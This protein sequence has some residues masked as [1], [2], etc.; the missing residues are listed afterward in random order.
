MNGTESQR[1]PFSKLLARAI[2][3]PGL[4]V[5]GPWGRNLEISWKTPN[6]QEVSSRMFVTSQQHPHPYHPWNCYIYLH[7]NHKRST[8]HVG[9][10]IPG[11][12]GSLWVTQRLPKLL[13]NNDSRP[14]ASRLVSRWKEVW[15]F[16][17]PPT[18]SFMVVIT[19][20]A[21]EVAPGMLFLFEKDGLN[22]GG[23]MKMV[24]KKTEGGKVRNFKK[25]VIGENSE[26][27]TFSIPFADWSRQRKTMEHPL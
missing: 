8:I 18:C 21:T 1:T 11:N 20:S 9:R 25:P 13:D 19:M 5:R 3:Y 12:H 15:R 6:L 14:V 17:T 27:Y 22:A 16:K 26:N 7:E 24:W 4:G 10:N 23:K 2:R